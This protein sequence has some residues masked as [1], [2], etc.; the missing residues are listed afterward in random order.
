MENKFLAVNKE[1][2][3]LKL[4]SIDIL[5]LSQIDEFNRNGCDCYITNQQLSDMFGESV[6]TVERSL[7]KL[8]ELGFINRNTVV[9]R[10]NGQSSKIRTMTLNYKTI[11]ANA[12]MTDGLNDEMDKLPSKGE[13]ADVKKLKSK[14]QNDAIKDNIK[15]NKKENTYKNSSVVLKN[16]NVLTDILDDRNIKYSIEEI[17]NIYQELHSS[18]FM[19]VYKWTCA[20]LSDFIEERDFKDT[21]FQS[22]AQMHEEETTNRLSSV[23]GFY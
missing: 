2:F 12:K 14:R 13:E 16:I 1:Y 18:N 23:Y 8:D 10:D 3:N 20:S 17:T 9:S 22:V 7:K 5:I 19:N 4:K 6:K 11:K 21:D 15:D